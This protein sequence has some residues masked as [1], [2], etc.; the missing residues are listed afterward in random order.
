MTT[1]AMLTWKL[2]IT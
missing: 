2:L 1:A